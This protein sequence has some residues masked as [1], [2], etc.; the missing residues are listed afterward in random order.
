MLPLTLICE[1][2]NLTSLSGSRGLAAGRLLSK[3]VTF[4]I[5]SLSKTGKLLG[6]A[7]DISKDDDEDYNANGEN[8]EIDGNVEYQQRHL[9]LE[10]ATSFLDFERLF[11]ALDA[12]EAWR[13]VAARSYE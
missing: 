10:Q 1:I 3:T 11:V 9:L 5:L 12:I 13:D 7:I 2:R 6:R 4:S 8:G